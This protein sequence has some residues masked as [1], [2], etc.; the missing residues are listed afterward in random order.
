MKLQKV[1]NNDVTNLNRIMV[2]QILCRHWQY[3]FGRVNPE[4]F[5]FLDDASHAIANSVPS[6]V[7]VK[8]AEKM[9]PQDILDS[10]AGKGASISQ[11]YDLI[12]DRRDTDNHNGAWVVILGFLGVFFA[13]LWW[14]ISNVPVG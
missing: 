5:T 2:L 4:E 14:A 10:P 8:G 13:L 9:T 1:K 3:K 7:L 11:K 12:R 6:D